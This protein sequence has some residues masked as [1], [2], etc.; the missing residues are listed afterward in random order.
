MNITKTSNP[1]FRSLENRS[2][3]S[4]GQ[5][6]MS[7][8]GAATKAILLSLIIV[9]CAMYTFAQTLQ[10]AN[11]GGLAMMGAIGGF[12]LALVTAFK[13]EWARF[14]APIYAVFEGLFLGAVSG[15]FERSY[16][17]IAIEAVMGTMGTL[18][19][20][21]I[22]YKMGLVKV[23][24]KFRMGVFAATGGIFLVYLF[25]WILSLFGVHSGFLYSGSLFSIGFTIFAIII[26]ALNLVLDF[27]FIVRGEESGLPKYMEWYGAFGL[28]VTLVWLY[29]E[30][31]NLLA[32][33][34][35]RD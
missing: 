4:Q 23:T 15:V 31:L 12:L 30:I 13:M 8:Q 6:V 11:M 7:A 35:Q 34:A 33:L 2:T 20:M 21:L 17:G 19:T 14:T 26:A 22:I 32:M 10:G 18:L 16:P 29:I 1:V 9:V 28:M 3:I 5:G 24:N 27:D 25:S